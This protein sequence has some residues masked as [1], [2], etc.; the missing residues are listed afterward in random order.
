MPVGRQRD[1]ALIGELDGIVQQVA[2]H[3]A[4][5]GRIGV[6]AGRQFI[7]ELGVQV[8]ALGLR[9]IGIGQRHLVQHLPQIKRARLQHHVTGLDLGHVE[10]VIDHAEQMPATLVDGLGVLTGVFGLRIVADD[11]GKAQNAIEGRAQ[12]MRHVG[13]KIALHAAVC[14]C[15]QTCVLA[16]PERCFD[17]VSH[18]VEGIAQGAKLVVGSAL[19]AKA[20]VA[21]F[22]A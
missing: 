7:A 19:E 10:H 18:F 9:G 13:H 16:L 8:Q 14:F 4:Q 17:A 3:L 15:L 21:T 12:L 22:H 2:H 5:P 1:A 6:Q 11:L 20:Q